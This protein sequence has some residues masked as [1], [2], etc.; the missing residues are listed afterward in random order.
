MGIKHDIITVYKV[1]V[2]LHAS[3]RERVYHNLFTEEKNVFAERKRH[4][5]FG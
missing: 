2:C 3:E 4:N 1:R 5:A